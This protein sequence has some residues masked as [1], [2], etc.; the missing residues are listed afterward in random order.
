MLSRSHQYWKE[1]R[2]K[3][4]A[5]N[6][7]RTKANL[8]PTIFLTCPG[9]KWENTA[10]NLPFPQKKT[11][12]TFPTFKASNLLPSHDSFLLVCSFHSS[13][14]KITCEDSV[15]IYKDEAKK[16]SIVAILMVSIIAITGTS[17][18]LRRTA[19]P[20][21]E[22]IPNLMQKVEHKYLFCICKNIVTV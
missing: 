6:I 7:D 14:Q 13:E 2:Q 20:L 5:F 15:L 22:C 4:R 1:V 16:Q 19:F 3:G 8:N 11:H 18:A 10:S 21:Y 17:R 12:Q 9:K